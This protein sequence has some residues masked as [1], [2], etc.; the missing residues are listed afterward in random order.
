[1]ELWILLLLGGILAGILGGLLGIGGGII[2]MPILRFYVGLSPAL[3]A[4]TCIMAVFFTTSGG[5][6]KHFKQGHIN[7]RS[8]IPIIIAG[9]ISTIIFSLVFLSF[10]KKG[11]WLDFGI[12]ILFVFVSMRMII[13]GILDVLKKSSLDSNEREIRGSTSGKV[14]LGGFAGI[15]PGLF[16]IGTGAILVPAFTYILNAPIK[17]AIGS[18]LACFSINAFLSSLIKLYQ[19]YVNLEVVFPLC[20][21]TLIGANL[22]ARIN[23]RTPPPLLKIIFGIVFCYIAFKYIILFL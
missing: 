7:F 14:V 4:G 5:S 20:L 1:M 10:T 8:I 3:A 15:F 16:G 23:K 18:S 9:A 22:G 6:F 17:V 12:G 11:F 2:L 13:E 19:G 21:G